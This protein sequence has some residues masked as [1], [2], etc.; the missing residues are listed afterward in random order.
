[1]QIVYISKNAELM[2]ETLDYVVNLMK[3][4]SRVTIILPKEQIRLIKKIKGLNIDILDEK[5][6]LKEDYSRFEKSNHV[7]KNWLLRS[8]IAKLPNT[9]I[10]KEFIM[11][12]D[13][14]RPLF[15]LSEEFFKQ[16]GTYNAYYFY[17]LKD[18]FLEGQEY[19]VAQKNMYLLLKSKNLPTFCFSS[20][21][22]QIINKQYF[23]EATKEFEE[24]GREKN[25]DE[26]STYFNYSLKNHPEKFNLKK[27]QVICWPRL[28]TDWPVL[29]KPKNPFF[30]NFYDS[31][32]LQNELFEGLSKEYNPISH[33]KISQEKIRRYEQILSKNNFILGLRFFL[34]KNFRKVRLFFRQI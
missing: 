4:I 27:Y 14:Y 1:M 11:S 17:N 16:K 28:P 18:W 23:I 30:E 33:D 5:S 8:A 25:I 29:F 26:W 32:Y 21:Q 10:E 15:A 12:D 7:K 22:P 24:I 20:H 34:I 9:L 19:D 2:N 13:D 3:F 6:I 31:N